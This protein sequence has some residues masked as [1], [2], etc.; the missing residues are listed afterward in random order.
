LCI[1]SQCVTCRNL[2]AVNTHSTHAITPSSNC[3]EP[4]EDEHVKPET[5]KGIDS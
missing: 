5:C 2:H 1:K 3:A 4:P